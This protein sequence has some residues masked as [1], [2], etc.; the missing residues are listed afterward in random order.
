MVLLGGRPKGRHT[1]QHDIYFGFGNELKD[2][3]PQFESFWPEAKGNMHV[4]A[5][6]EVNIVNGLQV[7][8]ATKSASIKST[9][10][11]KLFFINLG[12]YKQGEFDEFHYKVFTAATNK[13]EAIQTAKQTAFYQHTGFKDAPSHVDDRFGVDV[14]DAYEIEEVLSKELKQNYAIILAPTDNAAEDEIHLG[15][16]RLDKL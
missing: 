15:Y 16:F 9:S 1:E 5:W 10:E 7:Q 14:D 2:L 6:R 3:I 4:D 8:V 13:A 12:G 11:K